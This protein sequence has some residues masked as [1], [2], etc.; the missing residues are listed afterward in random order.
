MA[1]PGEATELLERIRQ[2]ETELATQWR[3][4]KGI[5]ESPGEARLSAVEVM[6]A[7]HRCLLPIAPVRE[8]VTMVWPQPLAEAPSWVM[9]TAMYGSRAVP[10]V[11]LGMRLAR[12][13]TELSPRLQVA[14]VDTP[15]WLGLVVSEV[16]RVL[17]VNTATLSSPGPEIP[18][19]DFLIG[20]VPGGA[21]DAV[22]LLSIGRLGRELDA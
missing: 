1:T 16:G 18:Y 13:P 4:L 20:V 14:I 12:V 3:R 5:G 21:G 10:L 19:A 9:G 8:V 22:H 6:A 15:R 2:L 7:E 17:E 11:D